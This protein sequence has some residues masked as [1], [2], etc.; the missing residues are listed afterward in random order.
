ML[1]MI[2]NHIV[3]FHAKKASIIHV[4]NYRR[5]PQLFVCVWF[6]FRLMPSAIL[7]G[8][9]KRSLLSSGIIGRYIL[10]EEGRHRCIV[11]EV[12]KKVK[13]EVSRCV[14]VFYS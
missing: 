11:D 13:Y 7:G 1:K 12:G 8:N 14:E 2:H 4:G 10:V 9:P 6:A 5:D 3:T